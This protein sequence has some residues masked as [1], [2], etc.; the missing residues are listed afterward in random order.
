[1]MGIGQLSSFASRAN[2]TRFGI[3][4]LLMMIVSFDMFTFASGREVLLEP[5]AKDQINNHQNHVFE[6]AKRAP[7]K[8]DEQEG[9]GEP[10]SE[11]SNGEEGD[12]EG[13][14]EPEE[15]SEPISLGQILGIVF[16]AC[17]I[18]YCIGIG[19][20][21]VKIFKG[22]YVEEEPVFLKYK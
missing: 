16:V 2:Q 7:N 22:T 11:G 14:A 1:M 21:I 8:A 5:Y 6:R 9:S 18:L 15:K 20:K 12:G 19:I 17:C 4:F 10:R 13:E 3:V